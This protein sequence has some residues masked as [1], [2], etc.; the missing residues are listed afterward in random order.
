MW[1]WLAYG[2]TEYYHIG[3]NYAYITDV[4]LSKIKLKMSQKY[5]HFIDVL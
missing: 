4:Q 3:M 5:A 1:I 2:N